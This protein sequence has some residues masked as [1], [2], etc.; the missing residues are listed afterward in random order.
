MTGIG[1]SAGGLE[2]FR[3]FIETIPYDSEMA[4]V[5]VQHLHP[6]HDTMLTEL[7]SRVTKGFCC[8]C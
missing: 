5:I 2:A 7:L 1:A 6:L 8:I 3:Q 4:Y